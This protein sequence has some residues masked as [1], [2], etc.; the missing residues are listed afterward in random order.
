MHKICKGKNKA[1]SLCMI[2]VAFKYPQ[3]NP[4]VPGWR[5]LEG[6]W[7]V[8][9][10]GNDDGSWDLGWGGGGRL[11]A[12]EGVEK[13][14]VTFAPW[15]PCRYTGNRFRLVVLCVY[16]KSSARFATGRE[17]FSRKKIYAGAECRPR[18]EKIT[19]TLA[20]VGFSSR[21]DAQLRKIRFLIHQRETDAVTSSTISTIFKYLQR[22][23]IHFRIL[24]NY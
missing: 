15:T 22:N 8:R 23:T 1:E 21:D 20:N 12:V 3:Y 5:R 6:R 14:Y 19:L 17:L 11:G 18:W 7:I 24:R 4:L 16:S 9:G 13:F 2:P 10:L